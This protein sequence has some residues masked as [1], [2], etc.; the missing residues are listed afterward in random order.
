L[1]EVALINY[2]W[3]AATILL[4]L[5]LL[6]RR[7]T[8]WLPVGAALALSGMFLVLTPG[9]SV[10]WTG[11]VERL[12]GNPA[13]YLLALVGALAWAFCSNLARRWSEPGGDG[14]GEPQPGK[15][16]REH[17]RFHGWS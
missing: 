10:S 14:A 5:P 17:S 2:L 9:A 6:R 3:P 13:A 4:S 1:L 16:N 12:L 15:P 8:C 11:F 7:G